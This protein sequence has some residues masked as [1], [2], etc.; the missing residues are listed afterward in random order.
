MVTVM[1][2]GWFSSAYNI[3]EMIKN[4]P[5]KRPIKII[6]SHHKEMG[7]KV[8]C[9]EYIIR[10]NFEAT[11]N[12]VGYAVWAKEICKTNKVDIFF[13]CKY[14]KEISYFKDE[15]EE[16]GTKVIIPEWNKMCQLTD[17]IKTYGYLCGLEN[18]NIIPEVWELHDLENVVEFKSYMKE[19]YPDFKDMCIKPINGTGGNGVHKISGILDAINYKKEIESG[20]YM[21]MPW[22]SGEEISVD[23]LRLSNGKLLS[24]PRYKYSGTR[25]QEIKCEKEVLDLVEEI[26]KELD[27]DIP[28]N[29]QFKKQHKSVILLEVNPRFSGGIHLSCLTGIN[30]PYLTIKKFL[31]EQVDIDENILNKLKDTDSIK[32]CNVERGIIV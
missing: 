10:E 20:E 28:Y 23:C 17:K 25:V 3:I 21:I 15:F 30:I 1:F 2:D 22:L 27:L 13:T 4:N 14:M 32:V 29:I 31:G 12:E 16:N 26:D 9:D 7:Y 18:E 24:V 5:D 19:R 11:G 6:G 8:L